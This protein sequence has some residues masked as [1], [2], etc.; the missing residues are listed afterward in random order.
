M[1]GNTGGS[2]ELLQGRVL[3][4]SGIDCWVRCQL[5][6][7]RGLR[8]DT[9]INSQGEG[10]E[11]KG[12]S[13]KSGYKRGKPETSHMCQLWPFASVIF[14][15]FL[16]GRCTTQHEETINGEMKESKK[17]WQRTCSTRIESPTV[18]SWK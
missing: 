16:L 8:E 15:L 12:E 11:E 2:V 3:V 6:P 4:C 14:F 13:R 18:L 7:G 1:L 10:L 17:T 9:E 5:V